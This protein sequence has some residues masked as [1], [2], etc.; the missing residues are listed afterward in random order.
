MIL[1]VI[2]LKPTSRELIFRKYIMSVVWL[3]PNDVFRQKLKD[4]GL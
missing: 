2:L 4:V 1:M 3:L